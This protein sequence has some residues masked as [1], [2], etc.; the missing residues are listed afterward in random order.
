MK[1]E[2][3]KLLLHL[4]LIL[5]GGISTAHAY[6]YVIF[7]D[8]PSGK[9][10]EEIAELMKKMYPFNKFHMEIEIVKVPP[11]KL[12]CQSLDGVERLVGCEEN[13]LQSEAIKKGGDQVFF[14]KD[15]S[16]Y[17][18][19]AAEGGIPAITTATSAAT[20]VHEYLHV[21][22]FHDEYEYPAEEAGRLCTTIASAPNMAIIDPLPSY[23]NDSFA[24]RKHSAEIPWYEDISS[25]TPITQSNE[26]ELGTGST[27]FLKKT[28]VN[29]SGEGEMLGVRT[30]LYRGKICNQATPVKVSWHPGDGS[31]IMEKT[32]N[33]LGAPLEKI[34]ENLLL[35]KG[36]KLKIKNENQKIT[37]YKKEVKS[38]DYL[39]AP[40]PTPP[41]A[42]DDSGRNFFKSFFYWLRDVL[43]NFGNTISR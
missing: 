16:K 36:L 27:D 6:K 3:L 24:R 29:L 32:E 40:T 5:F 7:T 42:V 34:V 43:I 10:S 14:V 4:A 8:E 37:K 11:E 17:G 41:E 12:K 13:G 39:P 9:K 26:S 38:V 1:I 35:S 22:G 23:K 33:G 2:K 30:G 31:T 19:S 18:G 25:T 21:L 28:P 15:L 20:M